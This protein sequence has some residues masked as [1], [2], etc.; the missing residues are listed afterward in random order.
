MSNASLYRSSAARTSLLAPDSA[1]SRPP[2]WGAGDANPPLF[3]PPPPPASFA[4]PRPP[5]PPPPPAHNPPG[6]QRGGRV[7]V[8]GHFAQREPPYVAVVVGEPAVPEDGV[9]EQVRG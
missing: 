1:P 3:R 8:V 2:Q 9:R 4:A 6:P 5:P 7:D